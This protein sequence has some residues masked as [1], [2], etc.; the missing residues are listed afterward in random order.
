MLTEM[1]CLASKYLCPLGSDHQMFYFVEFRIKSLKKCTATKKRDPPLNLSSGLQF[2]KRKF[3][4]PVLNSGK[5]G[6]GKLAVLKENTIGKSQRHPED[7]VL[8]HATAWT[9]AAPIQVTAV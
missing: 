4:K 3:C 7:T 5:G 6:T 2:W 1:R 9:A 8:S